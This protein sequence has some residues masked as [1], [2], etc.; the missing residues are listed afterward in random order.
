[1]KIVVLSFLIASPFASAESQKAK[2]LP[3]CAAIVKACVDAGFKPG[4]HDKN[5][6]GLWADCMRP[7]AKGKAVEGVSG[8]SADEAKKCMKTARQHRMEDK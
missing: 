8:P 1:M 5:G 3:E 2:D 6:K 4:A 7:L